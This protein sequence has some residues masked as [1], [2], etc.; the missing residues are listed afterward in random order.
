MRVCDSQGATMCVEVYLLVES[1]IQI[2]CSAA[3]HNQ[4]I[5]PVSSP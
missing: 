5:P 2:A 3:Q 4:E 1:S